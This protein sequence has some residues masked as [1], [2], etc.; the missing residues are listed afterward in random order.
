[1][2]ITHQLA[3]TS[4]SHH[5]HQRNE[6]GETRDEHRFPKDMTVNPLHSAFN[7]ALNHE[8]SLVLVSNGCPPA[9][10]DSLLH[11]A[12]LGFL[13][14]LHPEVTPENPRVLILILAPEPPTA[15]AAPTAEARERV[16]A[17]H[18]R[19]WGAQKA[20][21]RAA[22]SESLTAAG[23]AMGERGA[24]LTATA[25]PEAVSAALCAALGS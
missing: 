24:I 20:E 25:P 10:H 8:A 21:L 18:A 17:E 5:P 19:R 4:P 1:M 13:L 15:G 9:T 22:C 2:T 12:S 16:L 11:I 14:G 3:S 6:N 7:E 23:W